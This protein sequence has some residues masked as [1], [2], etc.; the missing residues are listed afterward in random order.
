MA[1]HHLVKI[2]A[3]VAVA[4]VTSSAALKVLQARKDAAE[5]LAA[6]A[7]ERARAAESWAKA[8]GAQARTRQA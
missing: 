6:A 8:A 4:T 2:A 7:E 1:S 3:E 5:D